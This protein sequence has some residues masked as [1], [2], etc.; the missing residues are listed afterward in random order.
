LNGRDTLVSY[1][2]PGQ[3]DEVIIP[4]PGPKQLF[5][6]DDVYGRRAAEMFAVPFVSVTVEHR[7]AAKQAAYMEAYGG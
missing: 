4:K 5:P 7:E 3:R 2:S 1:F 6:D